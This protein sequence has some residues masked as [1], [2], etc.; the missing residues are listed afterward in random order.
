MWANRSADTDSGSGLAVT[1]TPG[2]VGESSAVT[3]HVVRFNGREFY[4]CCAVDV[5]LN[6]TRGLVEGRTQCPTCGSRVYLRLRGTVIQEVVPVTTLAF[7]HEIPGSDC[8]HGVVC[9]DSALFDGR[10]CLRAWRRGHPSTDGEEV[11][12]TQYLQRIVSRPVPTPA[13]N[14]VAGK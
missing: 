2:V 3:P 1:A 6:A 7:V 14:G 11:E 8:E 9:S 13:T 10:E 12:L 5:L 4:V